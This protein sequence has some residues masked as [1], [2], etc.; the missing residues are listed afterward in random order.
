MTYQQVSRNTVGYWYVNGCNTYLII[1]SHLCV[2]STSTSY[3]AEDLSQYGPGCWMGC[4]SQLFTFVANKMF[5]GTRGK[6]LRQ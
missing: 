5:E 3:N 6:D 1:G 4:K 2:G